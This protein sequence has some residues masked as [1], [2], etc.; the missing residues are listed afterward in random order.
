M[1][2][3]VLLPEASASD[4]QQQDA[5]NLFVVD[6]EFTQFNHRAYDL[7]Q[8]IGDLYERKHFKSLENTIWAIEGFVD[9]YGGLSDDL[10]FRTAIH[11]GVHFLC[12]YI[13]RDPRTPPKGTPEQIIGAVRIGVDFVVKGW[14]RDR[15]WFETS[16]LASL[17]RKA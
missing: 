8:I 5:I 14:E 9:G 15:A 16:P 17:F 12:W 3:S 10:A 1:K 2:N 13:R 4:I 11:T 6:W 7:G